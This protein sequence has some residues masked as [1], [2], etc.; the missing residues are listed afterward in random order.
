MS[1]SPPAGRDRIIR[2]IMIAVLVWGAILAA[3]SWTLNHDVRRPIVVMACVLAFL[4]FWIAALAARRRR[5]ER[6]GE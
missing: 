6:Q 5:V 4:G 3:G 1:A 2:G